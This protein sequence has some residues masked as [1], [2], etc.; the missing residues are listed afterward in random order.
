MNIEIKLYADTGLY[1]VKVDGETI[2]ECLS[3][4]DVEELTVS[5]IK[6]LA[7]EFN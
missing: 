1:S 4:K 5:E 7:K 6:Q 3:K 2:L